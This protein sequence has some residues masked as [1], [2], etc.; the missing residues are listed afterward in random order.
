L[1]HIVG[2][3]LYLRLMRTLWVY[4]AWKKQQ[5][6][7]VRNRRQ[8]RPL[9]FDTEGSSGPEADLYAT[10]FEEDDPTSNM[11]NPTSSRQSGLFA[12]DSR[13]VVNNLSNDKANVVTTIANAAA[14]ASGDDLVFART[15]IF[16]RRGGKRV[17]LFRVGNVT[18]AHLLMPKVK[19]MMGVRNITAEGEEIVDWS[20]L[21]VLSVLRTAV[22]D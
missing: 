3:F 17:L 10:V 1:F 15:V 16:T 8:R 14:A 11:N 20:D 12:I 21:Q 6:K 22:L 7:Q 18:C 5:E 9:K 13:H 2:V 4:F 19:I